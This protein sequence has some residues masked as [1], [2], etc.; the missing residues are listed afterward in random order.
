MEINSAENKY[1]DAMK[2]LKGSMLGPQL[3]VPIEDYVVL[4]QLRRENAQLRAEQEF[5]RAFLNGGLSAVR[6][7]FID[8]VTDQLLDTKSN[9]G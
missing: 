1:L 3:A 7:L 9:Q 2:R 4:L 5:E 6:Q 8:H